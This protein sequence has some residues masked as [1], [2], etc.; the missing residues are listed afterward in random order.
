M[1]TY[2]EPCVEEQS[3]GSGAL[4][5]GDQEEG[6]E[7]DTFSTGVCDATG[8]HPE[9]V[10]LIP[11]GGVSLYAIVT[12][13]GPNDSTDMYV[14]FRQHSGGPD[15]SYLWGEGEILALYAPCGGTNA[16][17]AESTVIVAPPSA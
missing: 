13:P 5:R 1:R 6:T 10:V 2:Q 14:I 17:I 9:D 7:V 4:C 8:A 15:F 3:P 16:F 11:D 12:R